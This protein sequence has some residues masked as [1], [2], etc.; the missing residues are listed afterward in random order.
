M[1]H[2]RKNAR[3]KGENKKIRYPVFRCV[4]KIVDALETPSV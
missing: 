1:E 4:K 2:Y 3:Y